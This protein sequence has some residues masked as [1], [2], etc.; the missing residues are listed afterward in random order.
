M[1]VF[2]LCCGRA[3][4]FEAWFRDGAAFER[5]AASGEIACPHCGDT[6]VAKA[7]MAPR[8]N[9]ARGEALE[10]RDAA[11]AML[12]E[13]R[14]AIESNCENVGDRFP[15]EARR[16]HYG[17]TEGRP[18]YGEATSEQ[19]RDLED[20]GIAVTRIPWVRRDD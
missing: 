1:I 12:T 18:I 16:I 13:L 20:E 11:R 9:S 15:E 3:H 19:A 7:P 17:E 5:Q 10:V 6:A 14:R 2:E 8:L 4:R